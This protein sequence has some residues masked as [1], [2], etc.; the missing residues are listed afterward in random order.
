VPHDVPR[1]NK[2]PDEIHLRADEIGDIR[3]SDPR[4]LGVTGRSKWVMYAA[5]ISGR[6]GSALCE[7]D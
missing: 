7:V 4:E 1:S 3:L 6:T 5:V 2:A